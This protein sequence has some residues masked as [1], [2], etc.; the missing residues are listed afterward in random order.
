MANPRVSR[1][2][3]VLTSLAEYGCL[4]V[5]QLAALHFTSLQMARR[6][7]NNL[8][9]QRLVELIQRDYGKSRGRPEQVLALSEKGVERLRTEAILSSAADLRQMHGQR[10]GSI[11]HRLLLNWVCIHVRNLGVSGELETDFLLP[12]SDRLARSAGNAPSLSEKVTS[13]RHDAQPISL[14]PDGVFCLKS[15]RQG[16]ALLFILEVDMGTEAISSTKG[17]LKDFRQK[18][19]RYQS[20][21]RTG[22][23]KRYENYWRCAFGGFRLLVVT[24]TTERMRALCRLVERT[25]P[26]GFIWLTEESSILDRGISDKIWV[27]GGKLG[28]PA[29]SI[30]GPSLARLSPILPIK[31]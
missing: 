8:S 1:E 6:E 18:I 9:R 21:F 2:L 11:E 5:P 24:S 7:R 26:S 23:Y 22:G 27:R 3:D 12:H 30:L 14:F 29:Q 17:D 25:T 15:A 4:S 28:S 19:D 20:Y 10:P 16:K 31:P 13:G